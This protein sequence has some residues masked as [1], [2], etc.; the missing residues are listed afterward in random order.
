MSMVCEKKNL[1]GLANILQQGHVGRRQ[2]ATSD[3][4]HKVPW[5]WLTELL[6]GHHHSSD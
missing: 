1:T 5:G 4:P 3:T 6:T 2:G